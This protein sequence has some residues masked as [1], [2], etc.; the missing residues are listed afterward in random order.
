MMPLRLLHSD[1]VQPC[2]LMHYIQL[3]SVE[4]N[5]Q[6]VLLTCSQPQQPQ[7]VLMRLLRGREG[8]AC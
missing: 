3:V 7:K 1:L 4:N 2:K 6:V 5:P 8:A